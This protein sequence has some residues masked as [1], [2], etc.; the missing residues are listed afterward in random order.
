M[1]KLVLATFMLTA[2]VIFPRGP[3]V[4]AAELP[5]AIK[6]RGT[7]IAAI[8][9]NYPPLDLRDWKGEFRRELCNQ[10]PKCWRVD[11]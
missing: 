3:S 1:K 5:S 9:P 6:A 2:A 8:V 4:G 7:L 10:Y 11:R